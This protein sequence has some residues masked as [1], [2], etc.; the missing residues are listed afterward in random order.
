MWP[1]DVGNTYDHR[2]FSPEIEVFTQDNRPLPIDCQFIYLHSVRQ[3]AQKYA[4]KSARRSGIFVV[5]C[6]SYNHTA[7]RR[8]LNRPGLIIC[9][10]LWLTIGFYILRHMPGWARGDKGWGS[11]E[12]ACHAS[13]G[14]RVRKIIILFSVLAFSST[15]MTCTV[16]AEP[17][18]ADNATANRHR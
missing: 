8:T 11:V 16:F 7:Y 14:K 12:S 13:T 9:A 1:N 5:F 4:M 18:A 6:W 17:T 3:K 10:R 2:Q 15:C